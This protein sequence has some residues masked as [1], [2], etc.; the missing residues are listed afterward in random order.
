MSSSP[1]ACNVMWKM[2]TGM[3]W[4]VH[5]NETNVCACSDVVNVGNGCNVVIRVELHV[6]SGNVEV[7]KTMELGGRGGRRVSTSTGTEA[8]ELMRYALLVSDV[9][10]PWNVVFGHDWGMMTG[11]AYADYEAMETS[12]RRQLSRCANVDDMLTRMECALFKYVH[13]HA[14]TCD[15][16]V[17]VNNKTST[18][19]GNMLVWEMIMRGGWKPLNADDSILTQA[20]KA[21]E[22]RIDCVSRRVVYVRNGDE[23]IMD[24]D[25]DYNEM[26]WSIIIMRLA[27]EMHPSTECKCH[28]SWQQVSDAVSRSTPWVVCCA[29]DVNIMDA[30]AARLLRVIDGA[31][32]SVK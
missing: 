6:G 8:V 4:D 7:I 18:F 15:I 26:L 30:Y 9:S 10:C 3:V 11:D 32:S 13:K 5:Q 27:L 21:H 31:C 2:Y 23:Y 25:A 12:Y 19:S 22:L 28:M 29:P 24:V 17:R 14:K 16:E 20:C 1:G